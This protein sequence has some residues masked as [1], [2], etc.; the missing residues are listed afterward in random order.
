M[1]LTG[2]SDPTELTNVNAIL[3][4]FGLNYGSQQILQKGPN[5]TTV[6]ITTWYPHPTSANITAVGVDNGYE[7]QSAQNLGTV[8]AAQSG[9]KV[10]RA[11]ESGSGKVFQWGDEWIT[12]DSEWTQH[13]D[14]QVQLFWINIIKWLT[15][16]N[17]CQVAIPPTLIN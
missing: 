9:Y 12:Y 15:P 6:A 16:S 10:G 7:S 17:I 4:A 13:P 2:F 1:T 3:G 14:Y 11:L 8:V 5:A